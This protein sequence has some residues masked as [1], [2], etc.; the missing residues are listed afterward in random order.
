MNIHI[1]ALV[2][3]NDVG[4]IIHVSENYCPSIVFI[5]YCGDVLNFADFW[6]FGG[7][8]TCFSTHTFNQRRDISAELRM[9]SDQ[10]R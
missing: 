5:D 1:F 8:H 4:G 9:I 6:D 10:I 7:T 3:L 2:C